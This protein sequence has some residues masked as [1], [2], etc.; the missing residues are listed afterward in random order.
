MQQNVQKW[1]PAWLGVLLAAVAWIAT[2]ERVGAT[3]VL[4]KDGRVLRGKYAPTA[5]LSE[6]PFLKQSDDSDQLQTIAVLDDNLRRTFVSQR[7]VREVHE[8]DKGPVDEEFNPRQ[9][10]L[11]TGRSI[12]SVGPPLQ[13]EPFDEFGRRTFTMYTSEGA[14]PV[15][16]G[17]TKLTPQWTKVEGI[18][19][20]WDM[21]IATSTIPPDALQRILLKQIT[22]KGGPIDAEDYKKVARFYLQS[23]RYKEAQQVLEGL[24]KAYPNRADLREQ[25]TPP[26]RS[27]KQLLAQ[28]RLSELRL[29]R[30][31]GQHRF[32]RNMLGK[33][34]TED[35][36]GEVLQGVREMLEKYDADE[37]RRQDII[38]H[39]NALSGRMSD[40]IGRENL[41][42]ILEEITAEI[43]PNTLDRMA[44][45]QQ[46]A[47]DEQTPDAEKIAL[48]IS[49]WLLGADSAT[50]NLSSAL[51]AYRVRRSIR[52]YL[53]ETVTLAREQALESIKEESSV[54]VATIA[55]LLAHMKPPLEPPE[56]VAGKPNYYQI[57]V[58]GLAKEPPVPYYVQ[59]PPEYDPYRL[60]PTIVTL[61]GAGRGAEL[62][63]DWWAGAWGDDDMRAG[64]AT[65]RGYIV[66]APAWTVEHQRQYEYSAR[67]HAAVLNSLRDA[68]RRFAIDTDRVY[69]SGH[70]MGGD[71]AWDIGL[72]HPDLWAGVIPIVAQSDRYCT[73][74][75][76]NA[77]Y[78]PFYVVAGELDGGKLSKNAKV[79]GL[80]HYL[81][82]GFDTTVVEFQGRGHE[83]FHDEIL[84]LFDWMSHF[85]RDFFPRKFACKTMRPW[86]NYFWW[87]ELHGLPPK[88]V[89]DPAD[90]PP[91]T[92]AL[93]VEVTGTIHD[94]N[95]LNVQAGSSQVT[96]WL[97]PKMLDFK[98][99]A[100]ITVNGRRLNNPDQ[101]IRPDIRTMLEDVR[102]RGDRQHPFWARVDGATGRVRGG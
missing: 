97:S 32:V 25:L 96:V 84:R 27:I 77:R 21:R 62:Q 23:E 52:E 79:G 68:C 89:V 65:R 28:E 45:F 98:Q 11:R 12:S 66:V 24:L 17:I 39:L 30:D 15:I 95:G 80:N 9:R 91:P 26:L 56:P 14:V 29:R 44:A 102:T 92:G 13:I 18:S 57:E 48:A 4:L 42:P 94:K 38:K 47:D 22:L 61:N 87:V 1:L 3:E 7:L 86:D 90:W 72:A 49:G 71:A 53:N 101:M 82:D 63:V 81:Q 59:L 64:Q 31:A 51:A 99:R 6:S 70:S 67:E 8:E 50:V 78:V 88:S 55:N 43:G 93:P 75:W 85:R 60:Y 69:L 37:A 16:Q 5:S 19:H 10:V 20:V 58:M 54:D 83:D 34:P 76:K 40:T 36:G 73:L 46:N 74:Y 100:T 33:F 35:V 41:K 2:V